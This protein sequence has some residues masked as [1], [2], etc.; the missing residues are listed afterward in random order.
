MKETKG[1]MLTQLTKVSYE[2]DTVLD[3]SVYF[4]TSFNPLKIPLDGDIIAIL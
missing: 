3:V 4:Q 2:L 1:N